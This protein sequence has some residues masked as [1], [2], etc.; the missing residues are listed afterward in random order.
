MG[1]MTGL[2]IGGLAA[3]LVGSKLKK[4][5]GD[6]GEQKPPVAPPPS[7]ITDTTTTP[8]APIIDPGKDNA[9]AQLAG[10]KARKRAALGGLAMRPMI[11]AKKPGTSTPGK[12][13]T[14]IG[15]Y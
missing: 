1:L 2:A 8:P 9:A 3:A 15:G 6:T 7:G 4:K 10:Q 5:P 11:G 13:K 14:L 12:P